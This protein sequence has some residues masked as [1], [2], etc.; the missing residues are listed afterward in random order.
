M[1]ARD[2]LAH[3]A[4][5]AVAV[6]VLAA[7]DGVVAQQK[8]AAPTAR[9]FATPEEATEALVGAVRSE[10][11]KAMLDILGP[12]ARPLV[13]TADQAKDRAKREGFLKDFDE[14]HRL[15]M[16]GDD[17]AIL[18]V[19]KDDWPMPIPIVRS[20]GKWY[21]DTRAGKDEIL[22]RRIGENELSVI[23]TCL[24]YVDAQREYYRQPHDRS[25]VL[26]YAQ[27]IKSTPG[28]RDGLY[29]D[30]APNTPES[31][32]GPLAARASTQGYRRRGAGAGPSPYHGYYFR[33]L[34]SQGPDA[35]GGAYDYIANGHM[36]GGF[37]LVAFPAEY[38]VTGVMSFIV[39]QDGVVYQ[40]NLGP[41]TATLGRDMKTFN[42]DSTWTKVD[43]AA[44]AGLG[45]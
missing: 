26:E 36:I 39:N 42:P 24:A 40:K 20:K 43:A 22:N 4:I 34:T 11:V 10:S 45:R 16:K 41:K 25:G 7:A 13:S 8:S 33:I 18:F 44:L 30:S 29:W 27:K 31:P 23:Q 14:A 2:V 38:G 1:T 21:F 35:P 17:K 37:A 5:V 6:G 19:G 12:D 3:V 32:L 28:L 9:R 15:E